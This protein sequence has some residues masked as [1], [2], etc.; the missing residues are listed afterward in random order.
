MIPVTESGEKPLFPKL[1]QMPSNRDILLIFK[2]M[3]AEMMKLNLSHHHIHQKPLHKK[4]QLASGKSNKKERASMKVLTMKTSPAAM[5]MLM[6]KLVLKAKLDL[7]MIPRI[8][9]G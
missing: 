6:F 1:M 9:S 3:V 4:Y 7:S 8:D 2:M 5:P